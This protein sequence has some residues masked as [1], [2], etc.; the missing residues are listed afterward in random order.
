MLCAVHACLLVAWLSVRYMPEMK[1]KVVCSDLTPKNILL[2]L[3]PDDARGFIAKV[4]ASAHA[5]DVLLL[6]H[7]NEALLSIGM[8][9]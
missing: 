6:P 3:H 5:S 8:S 7:I 4:C 1:S 9:G 2:D